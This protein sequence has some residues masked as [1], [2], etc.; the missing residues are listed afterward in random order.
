MLKLRKS[1]FARLLR[2]GLV[3]ALALAALTTTG[4]SI[5]QDRELAESPDFRVRVQA[6][7]R[8][9]RSGPA[10]RPDLE[11]ALRD[12]HPAVRVASAAAL[13]SIGDPAAIPALERAARSESS[14][15]V[16]SAMQDTI[17]RLKNGASRNAPPS[18]GAS[19]ASARYVVQLGAM[20]NMSG[21]RGDDLDPIM[22]QAARAKANTMKDTVVV[23]GNDPVVLKKATERRIP[24]LQIDGNLIKLTNTIGTDGGTVISAKVD[25]SIR[26]LPQQTLKGTVSGNAHASGGARASGMAIQELQNQVVG[27]AVESALGSMSSELA[28]LAR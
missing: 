24:V 18:Q 10:A 1:V 7:L 17:E 23:D 8:L 15:T 28:A 5:A 25:M 20:R 12:S 3:L 14:A 21:M 22:R 16:K 19:L 6:A 26:K 13:A 27:G 2:P 11:N 4:H 9:G